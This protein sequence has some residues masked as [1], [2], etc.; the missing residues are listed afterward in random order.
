VFSHQ[1]Q[2]SDLKKKE[3]FYFY[4]KSH[5]FIGAL[6]STALSTFTLRYSEGIHI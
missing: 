5:A 4:S 1:C 2:A 6:I 3:E